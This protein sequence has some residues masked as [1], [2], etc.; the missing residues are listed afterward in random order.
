MPLDGNI[1]EHSGASVE[2]ELQTSNV[3]VT[4]DFVG[5]LTLWRTALS[6]AAATSD[7]GAILVA[8]LASGTLY[9]AMFYEIDGMFATHA[10]LG[11][12]ISALFIPS[13]VMRRDYD[14]VSLMTFRN[15]GMRLFM[16]WNAAFLSLAILAFV[17][18]TGD[19]ISRGTIIL[20]YFLGF[21]ALT[22][23][24]ASMTRIVA[25]DAQLGGAAARRVFLV[26]RDTDIERF[27]A[28]YDPSRHGMHIVSTTVLDDNRNVVATL[29]MAANA[30]R[31]LR[32]DDIY[33]L[34]PLS[35][36]TLIDAAMNAFLSVPAS[37]HLGLDG[38]LDRFGKAQLDRIG[39][40]TS[41]NLAGQPL[42]LFEIVTKRMVD[43]CGALG[44]LVLLAPL[45]L[46]TAIAIK[47]DSRGPVFFL[48]R[49]Y[50]FNQKPFRIF[51]FRSMST[52]DDGAVIA[53]ARRDDPRVTRVGRFIRRC[54]IDELPQLLNVL[55]GNMSLVGPR[56]HAL[57]H[58][59]QYENEIALYARRHNV[60][61]GIT[62]W[63]Q[64]NG[65]RGETT[66]T[67]QMRGRVEHDLYYI[68]NWS[69]LF[70]LKI[71]FL[72]AFSSKAYKNAN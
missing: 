28:R 57:A 3:P 67:D 46:I 58:N 43:I 8:A 71:M 66:T 39:P 21:F 63:A 47:L 70:D 53:Q 44:A 18:R 11:F 41:L 22:A 1:L 45:F 13:G 61:P 6:I 65:F 24:R 5:H 16:R 37:L 23:A 52:M 12:A 55:Q 42:N 14:I 4:H 69:L 50:G 17:T 35:Q 27:N 59:R 60:R 72:T 54:N 20:T 64:V 62:G 26:G 25:S 32:P 40:V 2:P 48:Q 49:R 30:A 36:S 34:A 33:I 68:D 51:K 56:P 9:H 15:Q 19:D 7:V 38:V 29:A 31:V 10:A